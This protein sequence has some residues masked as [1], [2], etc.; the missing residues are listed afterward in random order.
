M[1]N[2]I[3][4]N[5]PKKSVKVNSNSWG[6]QTSKE[7]TRSPKSCVSSNFI[8]ENDSSNWSSKSD[9]YSY[10]SSCGNHNSLLFVVSPLCRPG[11]PI[12]REDANTRS[13]MNERS[14]EPNSQPARDRKG[15]WKHS[16]HKGGEIENPKLF[17]SIHV[18]DC[19]RNSW[20][21][22]SGS[23]I[24]AE[25]SW[26]DHVNKWLCDKDKVGLGILLAWDWFSRNGSVLNKQILGPSPCVFR[27]YEV[28]HFNSKS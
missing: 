25:G 13:N 10:S 8:G 22:G 14:F 18:R 15:C 20:S 2:V 19:L 16:N 17:H 1:L 7:S 21:N 3:L 11:Q 24:E 23:N 5:L 4:S 12:Q 9:C 27:S 6:S 26:N 28:K